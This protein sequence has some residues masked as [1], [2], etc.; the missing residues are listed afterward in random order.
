MGI[1]LLL[2]SML[3]AAAAL[4]A[5]RAKTFALALGAAA[6]LGPPWLAGPI[7]LLRGLSALFGFM[8]L[9][10]VIDIVRSR[11]RWSGWRRL[12][13][14]ASA[15]DSR[16]LRRA[17]S[18][19][20]LQ[21]PG[22]ALL[23]TV[24]A[25]AGFYLAHAPHQLARWG[26]GL[27][28][29]YA[30]L[31]S[32]YALAAAALR[33]LGVVTPRLH[34][35]PL[36]SLSVG[37]LWGVRWARPISTWLRENCL[38]PLARRGHARLGLFLGFVVSAI[39]HAYPIFVAVG[40]PMA[41]LMFVFFVLQGAVVLLEARLGMSHWPRPARRAWTITIMIAS[42]PLFVEPALRVLGW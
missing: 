28:F 39:G 37:E 16:T 2:Q 26:G 24:V 9:L 10:R 34:V 30:L 12:L 19:L 36:A 31:E 23:W 6:F 27:V 17:S 35:L 25:V 22:R 40:L 8:L 4:L 3:A 20:D 29:A 15:L 13:H 38:R 14:V 33:A 21:A 42:S 32:G 18:Q 7:P 1:A 5:P 41:V 11:E